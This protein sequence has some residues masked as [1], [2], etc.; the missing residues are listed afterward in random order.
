MFHL[1]FRL[2]IL[3]LGFLVN[4]QSILAAVEDYSL[5]G[6]DTVPVQFNTKKPFLDRWQTLPPEDLWGYV[7]Q[8]D[9]FEYVN[10]AIRC[11][12]LNNTAV[13]DADNRQNSETSMQLERIFA[14][15]GFYP[16]DIPTVQTASLFGRHYYF[17]LDG[18]LPGSYRKLKRTIGFGEFRYGPGACVT[19][20]PSIVNENEILLIGGDFRQ[21]PKIRVN[22]ILPLLT[23]QNLGEDSQD[24][25]KIPRRTK[26]LLLGLGIAEYKSRSEFEQAIMVG[27]INK[28]F[29]FEEI[30]QIF[31]A[32]PAAG[33]FQEMFRED[34]KNAY[35]WLKHSFETAVLWATSN[36]SSPTILA[37]KVQQWAME[38]AWPG[39]T[40]S[41]D[42]A[43][44]LAHM[45]FFERAGQ[46][47]YAASARD[48]AEAAGVS[49][50]TA[51]KAT[52][53]LIDDGLVEQV[54]NAVANLANIY[55]VNVRNEKLTLP[56][57]FFVGKCQLFANHD[58]FR[59]G[60][61]GKPA[62]EIYEILLNRTA[63]PEELAE[64][65]GRNVRTIKSKLKTMASLTDVVTGEII[66]MVC[67]IGDKWQAVEVDLDYVA[68][69]VGTSG[70]GK[71]QK[72][73]HKLERERHKQRLMAGRVSAL[74]K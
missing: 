12:G 33:K 36:K 37:E 52:K 73:H 7:S 50:T 9:Y 59:Q 63:S 40:G 21:L 56:G 32:Y 6:F 27:L 38:R 67:P 35:R 45:K 24:Q 5:L 13:F 44:F 15:W 42:R 71:A 49:R 43:I 47:Q 22:Q 66:S 48:L 8:N 51:S 18:E 11:G 34:S 10:L 16:G 31:L 26:A 3:I 69:I 64:L 62:A 46:Y 14:G 19:A 61:L 20:P 30:Y 60:G 53:R 23:N 17:S 28:G 1:Y 39:R 68:N 25:P 70:K 54:V 2:L 29:T 72:K 65:T 57:T 58:V 41:V 55:R 4:R 74:Q